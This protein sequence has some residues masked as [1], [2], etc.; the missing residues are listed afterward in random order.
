RVIYRDIIQTK[1]LNIRININNK[2]KE[3]D[4]QYFKIFL[5]VIIFY[6]ISLVAVSN[7]LLYFIPPEDFFNY[8]QNPVEHLLLL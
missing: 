2:Q 7:L 6:F 4:R 5:G 8:I 3:Y 1:F